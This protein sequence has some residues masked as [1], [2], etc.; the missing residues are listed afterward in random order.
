[1]TKYLVSEENPDGLRLEAML[2]VLRGEVLTRCTLITDDTRAE[3][4]QV[5]ANNIKVLELLSEAI[6]L[7]ESSTHTLDKAFGP[8][9]KGGL[10]RIGT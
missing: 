1:M 8:S 6:Q 2:R 7:A 5:L 9:H 10:P 4:Q 3:A